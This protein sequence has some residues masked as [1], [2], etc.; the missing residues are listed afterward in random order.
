MKDGRE[1]RFCGR[2]LHEEE[3]PEGFAPKAPWER[4]DMMQAPKKKVLCEKV[5]MK[6]K[7]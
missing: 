3:R 7:K 1:Q 4:K 6:E 2:R 5:L